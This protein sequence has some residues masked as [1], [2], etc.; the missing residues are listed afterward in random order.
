MQLNATFEKLTLKS[1]FFKATTIFLV[2]LLTLGWKVSWGQTNNYFGTSGTISGNVWSTALNGPYTSAANTT[3]GWIMNFNNAGSLTWA[4]PSVYPTRANFNASM[5]WTTGGTV[6]AAST[7]FIIDVANGVNIDPGGS[8]AFSNSATAGFT[9]NGGGS[10]AIVGNTYGGGFTLNAGTIIIRGVNGLGGNA[11]PGSLTINGGT[12]AANANRDLSGKYSGINIGGDFQLGS[13]SVGISSGTANLTFSNNVALGNTT[14]SITLGGTGT[15]TFSG[16]ISTTASAGITLASG[17]ANGTLLLSGAN[18]YSGNT[19]INGGTLALSGSGSIANSPQII[20]GSGGNLRVSG[21]TT[22]LTL[23]ASQSLRS[24][25]TG[26]NT[27]ATLTVATDKGLTM[28]AATPGSIVF[29]AYGGANGNS[30]TN[31]PLT[32]DAAASGTGALV[33]NSAPVTVTTTTALA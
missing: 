30:S 1:S 13:S 25:A 5:T 31:A 26:A 14:R 33:L 3:G 29:T 20:I 15:Y 12:I 10:F 11:T 27:T 22:A 18:T 19:T 17:S 4:T 2:F 7:N 32:I 9:K 8:Q 23:A 24:S 21:L 6:G 16:I 28:N